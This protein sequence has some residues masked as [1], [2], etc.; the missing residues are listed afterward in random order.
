MLLNQGYVDRS[1]GY[2][3]AWR[4]G[5]KTRALFFRRSLCHK[6]S[7]TVLLACYCYLDT[8]RDL[9]AGLEDQDRTMFAQV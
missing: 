4:W 1:V 7:V 8:T 9:V 5:H 3:K 6:S 2:T